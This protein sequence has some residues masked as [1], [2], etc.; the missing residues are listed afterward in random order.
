M[1]RPTSTPG[2]SLSYLATVDVARV[3]GLSGRRGA[4]LHRAGISSVADLLL[5]VPRRYID[6]SRTVPI[7]EVP[8]GPEVTVVARVVG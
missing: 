6:R 2:R 4:A 3:P 7:G 8:V 5:H 1:S